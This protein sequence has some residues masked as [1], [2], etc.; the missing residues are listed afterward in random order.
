ACKENTEV[1]REVKE[2]EPRVLGD[3]ATKVVESISNVSGAKDTERQE[4]IRGGSSEDNEFVPDPPYLPE[5]SNDIW[6]EVR[7][8]FVEVHGGHDDKYWLKDLIPIIDEEKKE[9]TVQA[10]HQL[11]K[12]FVNKHFAKDLV[13]ISGKLG[14]SFL[15]VNIKLK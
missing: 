9:L 8:E 6:G 4:S 5:F 2:I 15:G 13:E 7:K 10:D 14:F 3:A 12:E 11:S 1:C